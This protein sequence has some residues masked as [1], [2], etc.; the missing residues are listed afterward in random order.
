MSP[1]DAIYETLQQF[2]VALIYVVPAVAL[3]AVSL[4]VMA[5]DL[6]WRRACLMV[7]AR[8]RTRRIVEDDWAAQNLSPASPPAR[9]TVYDPRW[10]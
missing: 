4:R 3:A 1:E 10:G 5:R 9:G 2:G 6:R 8:R 7:I